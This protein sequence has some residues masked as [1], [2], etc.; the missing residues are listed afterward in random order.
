VGGTVV[1][2]VDDPSVI[3]ASLPVA[4]DVSEDPDTTNTPVDS[5]PP[6]PPPAPGQLALRGFWPNPLRG[7]QGGRV[8]LAL[9]PGE[10][11]RCEI[12]DV[13]GRRVWAKTIDPAH[14]TLTIAPG[15]LPASGV[16]WIRLTQG[17][18]SVVRKGLLL[19]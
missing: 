17:G 1:L 3:L 18:R 4:F 11:G 14:S 5:L 7:T 9:A 19:P 6:P 12:F 2:R 16:V 13:R 8:E 10:P 15:E